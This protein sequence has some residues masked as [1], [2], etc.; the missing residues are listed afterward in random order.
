[1]NENEENRNF[2][3]EL[4]LI[5]GY[6][7][8]AEFLGATWLGTSA[9]GVW[10]MNGV[11]Y[12]GELEPCSVFI[13]GFVAYVTWADGAVCEVLVCSSDVEDERVSVRRLM[14][15]CLLKSPKMA[16]KFFSTASKRSFYIS[17]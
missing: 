4:G 16:H 9:G 14:Y 2:K 7:R 5:S 17:R 13:G 10:K 8:E 12:H 1:M 6:V 11:S 3:K 15:Q